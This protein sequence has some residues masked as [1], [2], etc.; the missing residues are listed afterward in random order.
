MCYI[1]SEACPAGLMFHFLR[2]SAPAQPVVQPPLGTPHLYTN[3][4]SPQSNLPASHSSEL[5]GVDLMP[6]P[7]SCCE[8]RVCVG[9]PLPSFLLPEDSPNRHGLC[10]V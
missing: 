4:A 3:Y 7:G 9:A 5:L 1:I 6:R 8:V 2:I 10:P